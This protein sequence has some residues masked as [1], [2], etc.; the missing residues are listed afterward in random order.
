[1]AAMRTKRCLICKSDHDTLYWHVDVDTGDIWC[2]CNKCA[3]GYGLWYYCH[4]AGISLAE[5]LKNDFEFEQARPNEVNRLEWPRSFIPLSNPAAIKG[6]EYIRSRGL[7]IEGVDAYY[8]TEQEGIVFPLYYGD[9][10]AGAQ[11]RFIVPRTLEDGKE[12]KITTLP[13]SRL[14]LLF[15]GWNQEQ[16]MTDIKAIVVTEGAF[17]AIAL[18]QTLDKMYGGML[19]NP[20][21][22]VAA[23]GSGA[24]K[25]QIE[26][27]KE[28]KDAGKTIIVAPDS[29]E[30]GLKMLK[31]FNE[32]N[33]MTHYALTGDSDKDWN[34]CA[35]ELG[36]GLANFFLKNIKSIM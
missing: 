33:A 1:M 6:V 17:N 24:T 32:F 26:V 16:F 11:V 28:L 27:I 31:K 9:V 8:D 12:W 25:H 36:D 21:K 23:N 14:G 35:K 13:G 18:Q 3:T 15:Y 22:V 20:F 4:K 5:F 29:D 19:K 2:Y 34:N 30:A 7:Q 10:F